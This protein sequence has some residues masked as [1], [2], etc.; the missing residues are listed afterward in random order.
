MTTRAE[1]KAQLSCRNGVAAIAQCRGDI[2]CDKGKDPFTS[3]R[4]DKSALQ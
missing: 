1:L 4:D 3:L 2:F